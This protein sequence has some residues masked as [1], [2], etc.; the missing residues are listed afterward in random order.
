MTADATI[1]R[2]DVLHAMDTG[3]AFDLTFIT[4]DRK[5]GTGGDI[6]QVKGYKKIIGDPPSEA[7]AP[8]E[9][10]PSGPAKNPHHR[11]NKTINIYDPE[12]PAAHAITVHWR[13]II[14]F[15]HQRVTG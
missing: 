13:L 9:M 6:K 4:A 15:N 10:A 5:R 14:F 3:E 2:I 12:N 1:M 7:G 8:G 11:Q